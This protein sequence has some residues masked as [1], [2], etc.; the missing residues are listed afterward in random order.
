MQLT[1]K[2]NVES[3]SKLNYEGA[4]IS[5]ESQWLSLKFIFLSGTLFEGIVEFFIY[6]CE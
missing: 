2:W 3:T 1:L 6:M 5:Y 4:S